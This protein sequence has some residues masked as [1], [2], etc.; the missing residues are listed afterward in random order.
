MTRL[1][2]KTVVVTGGARGIGRAACIIMAR[3]RAV[4]L[5]SKNDALIYAPDNIRVNSVHPGYIWTPLVEELAKSSG[6]GV[7][8]FRKEL[9]SRHPIGHVGEPEDIAYGI[10]YLAPTSHDL[11]PA[12]NWSSTAGIPLSNAVR[13]ACYPV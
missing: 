3:E 13:Q 10:L 11:S 12:A 9:D 5:M 7:E 2:N 1:E 8:V 6:Q 4:R